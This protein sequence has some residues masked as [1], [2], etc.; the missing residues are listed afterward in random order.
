[1]PVT[2]VFTSLQTGLIN[3]VYVSPLAAIAMQWFTKTK[4][5]NTLKLTNA[6]GAMLMTKASFKKLSEENQKILK[7]EASAFSKKLITATRKDNEQAYKTLEKNNIKFVDLKEKDREEFDKI[8]QGVWQT[9]TG[10]LYKK[11]LLNEV[12]KYRDEFRDMK[13]KE[14]EKKIEDDKK[15]DKDK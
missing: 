12:L 2:D 3:A 13:K 1:M 10:K 4:Y 11:E 14:K 5:M 8:S 9:L 15:T 6:T 7:K